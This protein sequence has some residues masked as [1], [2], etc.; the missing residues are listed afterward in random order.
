MKKYLM[1]GVAAIA[2]VAAFTSCSKSNDVYDQEAVNQKEKQEKTE[3]VNEKYEAAFIKTFGQPASNHSWGFGSTAGSRALTRTADPGNGGEYF[4]SSQG[5]DYRNLGIV[6]PDMVSQAEEDFVADWF[7]NNKKPQSDP[8]NL[9][10]FFVLQVYFGNHEYHSSNSNHTS[11]GGQHMDWIC[12]GSSTIGDDHIYYFNANSPERYWTDGA[13]NVRTFMSKIM[14]M[15]NSSTE[16]FG[17]KESQNTENKVYYNFV[18]KALKFNGKW[19][20]YVGFDYENHGQNGNFNADGFYDDRI[21]K[22]VPGNGI[23]PWIPN[24]EDVYEG[25]IMAEDL[26]ADKNSDFDFNDVVFDWK[27]EGR[28][29]TIQLQAAGGIYPLTVGDA[30]VH[31][32]LGHSEKDANGNYSMIN[33]GAGVTGTAEPYTYTFP[34]NVEAAAINIPIV[35]T[36]DGEPF[37]LTAIEGKAASKINVPV[38]TRWV[39]EFKDISDAYSGFKGWIA[40]PQ[41]N[42]A[43]TSNI[44]LLY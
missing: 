7:Q 30:E 44:E 31:G 4:G 32:K 22:I 23:L 14:L 19:G 43:G 41:A 3:K 39:K 5:N 33:T 35:V 18:L 25:R 26:N 8:V 24:E 42:W 17:Y 15:L 1:T 40:D 20:Y 10:N 38:S 37:P 21:I 6:A 29:A 28:T 16:R 34:D 27:I 12:A 9:S 13:Y 2:F 36:I 11:I